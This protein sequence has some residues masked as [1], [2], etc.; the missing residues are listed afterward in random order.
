[1]GIEVLPPCV[2][3]GALEFA[4]VEDMKIRFGMGAIKNVGEKA[5]ESVL[6]ARERVGKFKSIFHLCEHVDLHA[7]GRA[8]I[9][10][11]IKAGAMDSLPGNRAQ[12]FAALDKALETG[13]EVQAD[14]RKGQ[15]TLFASFEQHPDANGG[16]EQLPKLDEW[17]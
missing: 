17:P 5:V 11:L 7:A 13:S 15:A 10:T 9:E 14:R 1:M 4:V 12:L 16:S 6:E 3:E 8:V 2:N